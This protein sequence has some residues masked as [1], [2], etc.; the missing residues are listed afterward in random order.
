M[1][2]AFYL[3]VYSL[4]AEAILWFLLLTVISRMIGSIDD[5]GR[6]A[7]RYWIAVKIWVPV[8]FCCSVLFFVSISVTVFKTQ[9]IKYAKLHTI[10]KIIS[11]I[12]SLAGIFIMFIVGVVIWF[13][14]FV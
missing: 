8:M 14:G 11:C 2:K 3:A 10:L 12:F 7:E 6:N 13:G 9:K 1:S 5:V 4:I